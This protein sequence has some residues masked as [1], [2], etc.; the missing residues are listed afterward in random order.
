MPQERDPNSI[1]NTIIVALALCIVCSLGVSLAAVG[2]RPM[3]EKNKAL[4][5]KKNILD[6][7]GIAMQQVGESP[8]TLTPEEVDAMFQVI[9][10]KLLNLETGNYI[11]ASAEE[12]AAFDPKKQDKEVEVLGGYKLGIP[13]R[14]KVVKVFIVKGDDDSMQ[15]VVLPIYGKGLWSTLYGFLALGADLESV[16][17][18]T[19]YE[20]AET[21]GLGGEVDNPNW[22]AQWQG[23]LLYDDDGMP[24]VGVNKGSAPFGNPYL[25]DGLSGATITSRGVNETVRYWVSEHGFGPYIENLKSG[26]VGTEASTIKQDD[27]DPEETEPADDEPTEEP[28]GEGSRG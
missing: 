15:Q 22:K 13:K 14:E 24:A 21:P 27:A 2:L 19:F 1:S 9:E 20:H 4:D 23:R 12:L 5:L 18:I 6:A 8:K 28:N 10:P 16:K 3:Q 11:D 17:G 25:V 26:S 7:T